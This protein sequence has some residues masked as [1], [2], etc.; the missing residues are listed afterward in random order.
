MLIGLSRSKVQLDRRPTFLWKKLQTFGFHSRDFLGRVHKLLPVL[1]HAVSL[2][3]Y[4]RNELI[5][6]ITVLL[7]KQTCPRQSINIAY[8]PESQCSSLSSQKPVIC[9]YP[10][11]YESSRRSPL[12]YFLKICFNINLPP[13]PAPTKGYLPFCFPRQN[14]LR[15]SPLLHTY[16]MPSSSHIYGYKQIWWKLLTTGMWCRVFRE[17]F[18]KS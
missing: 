13:M 5:S 17:A 8:V 2:P 1:Y 12:S 16:H 7:E 18:S 3:S 6:R 11:P 4:K 9:S 15:I 10:K 14:F